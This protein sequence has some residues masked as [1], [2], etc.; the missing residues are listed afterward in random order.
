M[1]NSF[2][3][4]NEEGDVRFDEILVQLGLEDKLK[5]LEEA[6]N[7]EVLTEVIEKSAKLSFV[8]KLLENLKSEGHWVLL[9]THSKMILN[10][11]EEIICV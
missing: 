5:P 9:F 6:Y 8:M 1:K 3:K 7:K 4:N 2:E 10:I 11:I